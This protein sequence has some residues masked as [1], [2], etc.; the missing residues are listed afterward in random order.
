V[1]W[2]KV[3]LV[4]QQGDLAL[5]HLPRSTLENGEYITVRMDQL[6]AR[7]PQRQLA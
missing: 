3:R 7:R 4:K 6:E 1:G 2:I 5:V